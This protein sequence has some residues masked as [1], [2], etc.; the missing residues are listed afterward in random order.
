MPRLRLARPTIPITVCLT[1][2]TGT[3][4]IRIIPIAILITPTATGGAIL[5][6]VIIGLTI[7]ITVITITITTGTTTMA[8][9]MAMATVIGVTPG[10]LPEPMAPEVLM[11]T[12]HG[13]LWEPLLPH[14][15]IRLGSHSEPQPPPGALNPGDLLELPLSGRHPSQ[16]AA[17]SAP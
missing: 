14:V 9:D 12:H 7:I 6:T 8:T 4:I 5:G 10:P 1:I 16:A 15:V 13:S 17:P 11:A 2:T 3:H